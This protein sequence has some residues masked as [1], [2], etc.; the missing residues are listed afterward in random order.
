MT[1]RPALPSSRF[2]LGMPFAMGCTIFRTIE[3][4]AHLS[5]TPIDEKVGP[6]QTISTHLLVLSVRDI[7]NPWSTTNITRIWT[8]VA[9]ALGGNDRSSGK[10]IGPPIINT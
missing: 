7:S 10:L 8:R 2:L 9:V 4:F 3:R 5:S 1:Y 6:S